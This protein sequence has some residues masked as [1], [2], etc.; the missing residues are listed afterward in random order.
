MMIEWNVS[1]IIG[2]KST[3]QAQANNSG[4]KCSHNLYAIKNFL[5]VSVLNDRLSAKWWKIEESNWM[6]L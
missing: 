2:V 1:V 3:R 5:S 4:K 6:R